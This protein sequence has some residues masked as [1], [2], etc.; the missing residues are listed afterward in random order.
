VHEGLFSIAMVKNIDPVEILDQDD[1]GLLIALRIL[2]AG[3]TILT[4]AVDLRIKIVECVRRG[5]SKSETARRFGVNRSTVGRY[6]KRLDE[7]DSLAPKKASGSR[8]KLD[9]STMRL[10]E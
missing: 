6:L 8:P 7:N 10:L 3:P 2:H 9:Q 1:N 5:V 4:N